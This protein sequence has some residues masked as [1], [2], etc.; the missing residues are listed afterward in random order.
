MNDFKVDPN[1]WHYRLSNYVHQYRVGS[2]YDNRPKDFCTYWRHFT[3]AVLMIG[4]FFA[5]ATALVT[6][7]G[8]SVW[9]A[10][11]ALMGDFVG[12]LW[13]TAMFLGAVAAFVALVGV[14]WHI[15][16][17]IVFPAAAWLGKNVFA[18]VF[19][20]V[21]SFVPEAK[22]KPAKPAKARKPKKERKPSMLWMKYKAWKE[23][24]CP[25]VS[26]GDTPE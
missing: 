12:S 9:V 2:Y 11:Q 16:S 7:V 19:S 8:W 3:G 6:F 21:R 10:I 24:Y 26:Y 1:S 18:P 25:M 5:V 20:W 17:Y 22:E 13:A 23:S 4:Y 15:L 14:A